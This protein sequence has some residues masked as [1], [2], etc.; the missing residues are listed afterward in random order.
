MSNVILWLFAVRFFLHKV[1]VL[2]EE[3][4]GGVGDNQSLVAGSFINYAIYYVEQNF[5]KPI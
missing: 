1:V 4:K 2:T 5:S 3:L